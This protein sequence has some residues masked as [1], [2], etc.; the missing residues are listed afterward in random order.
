MMVL[1]PQ[2]A[3]P[4]NLVFVTNSLP[5]KAMTCYLAA[6]AEKLDSATQRINFREANC[7]IQNLCNTYRLDSDLSLCSI[8]RLNDRSLD[9]VVQAQTKSSPPFF[10]RDSRACETQA[11]VK[12]TPRK[13]RPY[14]PNKSLFSGYKVSGEQREDPDQIFFSVDVMKHLLGFNEQNLVACEN[15]RF[16]SGSSPM[17]RFARRKRPSEA[18]S[19]EKRMFSQ[20]KNLAALGKP[21]ELLTG[22]LF[23]QW[24]V[25]S[26]L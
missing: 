2:Q 19:E 17:G 22:Q 11:R 3:F 1:P 13:K 6:F 8:Q 14:P 12:I 10:L 16:S 9:P 5:A 26:T 21:T 15:I 4:L 18:K 20:A 24:I 7:V 23:I 25:L